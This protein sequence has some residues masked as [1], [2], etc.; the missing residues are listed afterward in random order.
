MIETQSFYFQ[1]V[2]DY[3]LQIQQMHQEICARPLHK[4]DQSS[5]IWVVCCLTFDCS[6]KNEIDN[7]AKEA[8][9]RTG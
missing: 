2:Q 5:F 1:H 8:K 4:A 3:F 6:A 7:C 9:K